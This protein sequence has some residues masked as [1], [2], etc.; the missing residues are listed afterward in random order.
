MA[1]PFDVLPSTLRRL[2]TTVVPRIF[3]LTVKDIFADVTRYVVSHTAVDE[4]VARA[5]WVGSISVP[6]V[7]TIAPYQRYPK[8]GSA[9]ATFGAGRHNEVANKIGAINQSRAAAAPF[10]MKVNRSL[11]LTN[12]VGHIVDLNRGIS[13]TLQFAPGFVEAGVQFASARG[14]AHFQARASAGF[15]FITRG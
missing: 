3:N 4:G 13:P 5:N 7:G 12:N 11:F 10:N 14:P 8:L 9:K 6:F 15:A 2:R 1:K